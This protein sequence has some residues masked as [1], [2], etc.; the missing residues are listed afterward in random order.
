MGILL[1]IK[2]RFSKA[3][4]T[5]IQQILHFDPAGNTLFVSAIICLLLALHWGGSTY[6]YSNGR[7]IALFVLFGALLVGF[8]FTQTLQRD[9]TTGIN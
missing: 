2:Q 5:A 6:A 3:T 8:I 4:G 1:H 9:T 7:I